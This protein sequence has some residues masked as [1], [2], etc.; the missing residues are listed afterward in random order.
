MA[1]SPR[2]W[3]LPRAAPRPAPDGAAAGRRPD[4]P[5]TL[6]VLPNGNSM[7]GPMAHEFPR[8]S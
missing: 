4:R 3:P 7:R 1:R 8:C 2:R 6:W 5:P